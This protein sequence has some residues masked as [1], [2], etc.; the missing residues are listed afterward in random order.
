VVAV[1]FFAMAH[2]LAWLY[3]EPRLIGVM[4]ALAL[5]VLFTSVTNPRSVM[6]QKQLIFW[7]LFLLQVT[8][9]V[10]YFAVSISVAVVYKTYWALVIGYLASQIAGFLASY[11]VLPFFPRL[12]LRHA[13]GM[14]GFSIWLTAAQVVNTINARFDQLLLGGFLGRTTLGIFALGDNLAV[15]PT[16]ESTAP[17]TFTLFPAFAHLSGDRERLASAYQSAQSFVTSVALP[18]GVGMTLIAEPLVR[19]T[20]GEKW[21]AC[22][23]VIQFSAAAY[24][25]QTLGTLSQPLAMAAGRTSLVF[26]R[27]CNAFITHLPLVCAGLALGGLLGV[28]IARAVAACVTT[29][30]HMQVVRTVTGLSLGAQLA[31]NVR[32]LTSVAVMTLAI[33]TV[34]RFTPGA[35]ESL[36]L[37]LV[38]VGSVAFGA[39]VYLATHSILWVLTGKPVGPESEV[40]RVVMSTMMKWQRAR[41]LTGHAAEER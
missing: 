18:L 25:L 7:Q 24:A 8:Q 12:S 17:L 1:A 27:E 10:V 4:Q 29:V 31:A 6:L 5:S 37:G 41:R 9:K 33:L 23:P 40:L 39:A 21:L 20:L 16:R 32:S 14:F 34:E 26:R 38:L 13:K 11:I 2:P 19:F 30:L 15:I 36:S 3:T 28:L 35:Q 22:V